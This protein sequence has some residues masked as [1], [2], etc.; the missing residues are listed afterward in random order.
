[1]RSSMYIHR[2]EEYE[3]IEIT[4]MLRNVTLRTEKVSDRDFSLYLETR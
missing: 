1:M 4:S 3:E 2:H